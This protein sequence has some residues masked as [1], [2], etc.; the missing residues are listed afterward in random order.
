MVVTD[1]PSFLEAFRHEQHGLVVPVR[2]STALAA[3]ILRL[4][5]DPALARR[6]GQAALARVRSEFSIQNH[7]QDL[8]AIYDQLLGLPVRQR[9]TRGA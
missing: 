9:A 5:R 8:M 3:A 6:L 7:M 2:D 1:H 4:I